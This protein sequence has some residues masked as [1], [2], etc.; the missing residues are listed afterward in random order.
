MVNQWSLHTNTQGHNRIVNLTIHK[1]LVYCLHSTYFGLFPLEGS[2]V[3]SI[4][5][6]IVDNNTIST[7]L[8]YHIDF[9]KGNMCHG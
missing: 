1:L 5:L 9:V 3:Q 7:I 8:N 4:F 6:L 2:R